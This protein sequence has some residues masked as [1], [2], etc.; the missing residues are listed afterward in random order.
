M[1][2]EL[3]VVFTDAT[4]RGVPMIVGFLPAGYPDDRSFEDAIIDGTTAGVDA[5]ELWLDGQPPE[6][7]GATVRA[8]IARAPGS[9][10]ARLAAAVT[11]LRHAPVIGL[12]YGRALSRERLQRRISRV[13]DQGITDVMVPDLD[14]RGQLDLVDRWPRR[15]GAFV[16]SQGDLEP[17]RTAPNQPSFVYLRS[18]SRPTGEPVA[19]ARATTRLADLTG[20]IEDRPWPIL[21]GFGIEAADD[22]ARLHAAGADGVVVGSVVVRA[23][24]EGPGRV[25]EAIRRLVGTDRPTS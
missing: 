14:I 19:L 1:S 2:S 25:T 22:V 5:W 15:V 6:L 11:A 10:T 8:A 13:L 7:E 20:V 3:D 17:L 24:K 9:L 16:G 21:V 23:V 12:V 18:S 4:A